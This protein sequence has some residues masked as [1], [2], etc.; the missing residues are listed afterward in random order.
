MN[1]NLMSFVDD[2]EDHPLGID[3]L[4]MNDNLYTAVGTVKLNPKVGEAIIIGGVE[5]PYATPASIIGQVYINNIYPIYVQEDYSWSSWTHTFTYYLNSGVYIVARA[6]S[7]ISFIN[8]TTTNISVYGK[9]ASDVLIQTVVN[10]GTTANIA[11]GAYRYYKL[12]GSGSVSVT[13]TAN[14]FTQ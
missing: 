6:Q 12:V 10:G 9:E 13:I 14:A 2:S 4:S 1:D 7:T 11:T 5:N 3:S 8:N